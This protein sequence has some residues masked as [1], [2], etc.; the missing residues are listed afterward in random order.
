MPEALSRGQ[1]DAFAAWEPT[2]S[3]TIARNPDRYG[4]IGRQQSLSFFVCNR[5]VAEQKPEVVKQIAASLVRAMGWFRSDRANVVMAARWNL[6]AMEVL[7]GTKSQVT[8]QELSKNVL[9]DLDALGYSPRMS[10]SLTSKRSLLLDELEFLR[11][12]G[13]LPKYSGEAAVTGSFSFGVIE[14]VLKKP[15]QYELSRFDYEP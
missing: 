13:K 8:E 2:P 9:T 12:L 7:T 1:I 11:S 14:N 10:R 3:L 6:V 5:S 15:K 4:A